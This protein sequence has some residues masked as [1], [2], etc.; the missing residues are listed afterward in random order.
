[1][2]DQSVTVTLIDPEYR[3]IARLYVERQEDK[4]YIEIEMDRLVDLRA[5]DKLF[6]LG[7]V[8]NHVT[9]TGP[10]SESRKLI[11][12]AIQGEGAGLFGND[13]DQVGLWIGHTVMNLYNAK[14]QGGRWE[15]P[16]DVVTSR[17][18]GYVNVIE[19]EAWAVNLA[20]LAMVQGDI[21]GGAVAM[22]SGD[23][24]KAHGWPSRND[25]LLRAFVAPTGQQLR[26]YSTW[27]EEWK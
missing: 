1:M 25:I 24:L 11:A 17:F 20:R 21:T 14:W 22:L 12:R 4:S 19:P 7:Y 18:H 26:F 16:G 2:W 27:A 23:D 3:P 10:L 9:P 15:T 13:R 8:L 6:S 5:T